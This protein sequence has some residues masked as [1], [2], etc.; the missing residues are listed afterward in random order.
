M[1]IHGLRLAKPC[2]QPLRKRE[3]IFAAKVQCSQPDWDGIASCMEAIWSRQAGS[4]CWLLFGK[5]IKMCEH[6]QFSR[7]Q[8]LLGRDSLGRLHSAHVAVFG[9]GGVGGHVVEALARTG[10]GRLTLV[11]ADTVSLTNLN[12]QIVALHSTLGRAKVDVMGERVLDINP[13]A[14]VEARRCFFLPENACDFDFAEYDYVVDAVDTVA[15]KLAI[16]EAAKAAG[17][18]V[19]SAMGAG[20]KLDPSRFEVADIRNTSVCPL[21]KVMRRE[22][23]RRGIDSLKVV[24][25]RENPVQPAA[26]NR[27][28]HAGRDGD[29]AAVGADALDIA[30]ARPREL[31]ASGRR[32][33]PGS[34]AF[35][36]SA[37]G[38]IIA[39]EVVRDIARRVPLAQ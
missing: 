35:A 14:Q 26:D 9:I 39:G 7:T 28:G 1:R 17:T 22:L 25:S 2:Y 34:I 37:M 5:A 16:I 20:N 21:A 11:D 10:V 27:S 32:S 19:V 3:R 6:N 23:R 36:P 33:V 31:S 29:A 13:E 30:S 24:Y 12:R 15:A 18:P 38:L 8:L 4:A